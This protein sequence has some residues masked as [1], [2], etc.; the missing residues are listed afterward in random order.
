MLAMGKTTASEAPQT[1]S[2]LAALRPVGYVEFVD[3]FWA[4]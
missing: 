2:A 1:L 4:V 3:V